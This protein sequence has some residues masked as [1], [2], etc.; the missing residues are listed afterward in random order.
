[1]VVTRAASNNTN[2]SGL[3]LSSG[4]L[5]PG[6]V[7]NTSSY[8]ASV[9]NGVSSVVVTPTRSDANAAVVV[10]NAS[11]VCAQNRCS[12]IVGTNRIT[13]TV[14]A[15]DGV[16]RRP[17]VVVVTRAASN[18]T[19]LSGLALSS[20]TLTPAF[21]SGTSSY[22]ASVANGVS[23][24]VVTPTRSDANAAVVVANA[25]GVCAQNRCSL[26]VGT[27]RITTTVTAQDGVT[28]KAYVVVVT[29]R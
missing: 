22:A 17:Y 11:G 16:T 15:Q 5:T 6:F 19:N 4:T 12:L 1:M 24:V 29:R 18:N 25:S 28:K 3:A 9:A 14:T 23:S 2:L 10:A 27:N 20:G 26:I 7:S 8:A 21:V 13:M